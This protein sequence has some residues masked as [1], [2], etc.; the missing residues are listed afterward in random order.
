VRIGTRIP[1]VRATLFSLAGSHPS[2]TARLMLESK[3]I[4]YRR[5]D[6]IPGVHKVVLRALGFAET[7]VPAIRLDNG[8]RL[9][10]TVVISRELDA[11]VPDPPLFPADPAQRAKV[12]E[13]ERWGDEVLQDVPRRLIWNLLSRDGAAGRSYLEGAR[14]GIPVGLAARTAP[15]LIAYARRY[16]RAFDENVRADL[17]ALPQM[18]DRIDA[19]IAEGVL[20]G[21]QLNAADLQIGTSVRLLLTVADLEPLLAGRPAAE[22]ARRV[23][24]ELP[25]YAPPMLPPEWLPASPASA[26][27]ASASS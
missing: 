27:S 21:E 22:L 7:T 23:L 4:P 9:Q 14:L 10:R 1:I 20:G 19:W 6:L 5:I 2:H 12:E 26:A 15:P 16:N 13:A 8:T 11:L 24:P 18:L 17:A 25:G 3:R